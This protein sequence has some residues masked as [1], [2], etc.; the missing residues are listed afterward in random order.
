M[1]LVER[2]IRE[3]T[4]TRVEEIGSAAGSAATLKHVGLLGQDAREEREPCPWDDLLPAAIVAV[5]R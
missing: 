4:H 3:G 1:L 5:G 2:S